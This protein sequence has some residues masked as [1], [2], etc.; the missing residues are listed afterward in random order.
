MKCGLG[1]IATDEIREQAI[2]DSGFCDLESEVH[3][4]IPQV[5][6][7]AALFSIKDAGQDPPV[8]IQNRIAYA[9]VQV[10]INI[11]W[12]QNRSHCFCTFW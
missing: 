1:G 11:S 4:S 12:A 6:Q 9:M 8:V 10:A 3:F 7:H 5:K 2:P